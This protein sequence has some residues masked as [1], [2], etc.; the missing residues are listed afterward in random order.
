MKNKCF[1]CT[2]KFTSTHHNN[3]EVTFCNFENDNAG[4]ERYSIIRD[5]KTCKHLDYSNLKICHHPTH[6]NYEAR[7]GYVCE[8]W[9]NDK[10]VSEKGGKT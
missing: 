6:P 1:T 5:C 3:G 4:C 9:S 2:N 7:W 10:Y 8:N